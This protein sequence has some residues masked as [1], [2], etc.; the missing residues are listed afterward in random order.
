MQCIISNQ[1]FILTT[2]YLKKNFS[3]I[4]KVS[5]PVK[6]SFCRWKLLSWSMFMFRSALFL[7][8]LLPF[9]F[10]PS[11]HVVVDTP[12]PPRDPVL[13]AVLLELD[14]ESREED[15]TVFVKSGP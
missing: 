13:D 1:I 7:I 12:P 10:T 11:V 4:K 9:P 15:L 3:K 8:T 6:M 14:P 5:L 2:E